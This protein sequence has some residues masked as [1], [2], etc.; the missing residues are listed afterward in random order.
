MKKPRSDSTLLNLPEGQLSA[1]CDWLLSG[2]PQ[3]KVLALLEKEF[4]IK[5]S[6]PALSRFYEE[7]CVPALLERRRRAVETAEVIAQD[8]KKA[9]GQ[10]DAAIIDSLKQAVIAI[11]SLPNPDSK[12]VANLFNLVLKANAQA[13][14]KE[15]ISLE[16]EKFEF[17]AAKAAL[18]HLPALREIANRRGMDDAAKLQAVR[19]RLFGEV[20]S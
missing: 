9:P 19:K 1:L 2:L 16:R 20:P 17:D 4:K 12:Q 14:N 3:A 10:F 5:S 6:K 15:Q 13:L 18:T 11:T 8:A 7:V